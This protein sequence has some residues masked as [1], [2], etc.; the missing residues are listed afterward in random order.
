MSALALAALRAL[1]ERAKVSG[2]V[3]NSAYWGM[4]EALDPQAVLSLITAAERV[5]ALEAEVARLRGAVVSVIDLFGRRY[6]YEVI[7][8][9]LRMS[10]PELHDE[11]RS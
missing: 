8:E 6:P 2:A 1:A 3:V 11:P 10:V 5:P 7:Q 9:E 4:I